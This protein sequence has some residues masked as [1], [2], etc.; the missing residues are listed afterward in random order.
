MI[1]SHEFILTLQKLRG[2]GPKKI[3]VIAQAIAESQFKTMSLEDLFDVLI[4]LHKAGRLKGISSFPEF[5]DIEEANRKACYIIRKSEELDIKMV[6][7]FDAEFPRNLLK[8]V[9]E[10][11]KPDVPVLLFY[12]GRLSI[13]ELPAIA[14]IGTREPSQQGRVAGERLGEFFATH[15]CNIVS[16]LAVGCDT[17]GHRGA[18]K[19]YTCSPGSGTTAFL[20][21]GLDTIYPPENKDLAEE[22]VAKGGLLMSEY[23]IGEHVNRNYLVN[24]DRLQAALADA[25]LVIQTG[26]KGGTMHAVNATLAAGKKVY[27]VEYNQFIPDDRDAGNKW[28]INSGRAIPMRSH[29]MG[30]LLQDLRYEYYP[31]RSKSEDDSKNDDLP[32]DPDYPQGTL[33]NN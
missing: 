12:K 7:R 6:S 11:G 33:F 22:I 14:I 17:A 20:A 16:G 2:F 28:L 30:V 15:G 25:T 24:R 5:E 27:A 9:N 21:H 1:I 32:H 26:V 10:N 23:P 8:T 19:A 18:L 13:T 4:D 29:D 31:Q 3:E